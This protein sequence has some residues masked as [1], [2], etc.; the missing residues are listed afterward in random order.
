MEKM[1]SVTTIAP[2]CPPG[3]LG[4]LMIKSPHVQMRVDGLAKRPCEADGVDNA[5]VVQLVGDHCGGRVDKG[6]QGSYH[7]GVSRGEDHPFLPSVESGQAMLQF[8]MGSVGPHDEPHPAGS[9][10][11]R[12]GGDLFSPDHFGMQ[13]QPQVG[14]GVHPDE[15]TVPV[16]LKQVSGASLPLRTD[17]LSYHQFTTFGRP[18]FIKGG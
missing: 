6:N 2:F 8:H 12:P 16:A 5:V 11:H 18:Q 17:D 9:G 14:V 4:K 15:S 7:G 1:P 10:S 13:R 3:R